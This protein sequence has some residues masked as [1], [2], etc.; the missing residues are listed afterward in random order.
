MCVCVCV[1]GGGDQEG[2]GGRGLMNDY[3]VCYSLESFQCSFCMCRT[4]LYLWKCF[5]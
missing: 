5:V 1:G 3:T 4:V 2:E